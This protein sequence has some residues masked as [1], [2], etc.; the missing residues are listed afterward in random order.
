[1]KIILRP[2]IPKPVAERYGWAIR[3]QAKRGAE[4]TFPVILTPPLEVGISF[5]SKIAQV[6]HDALT[7]RFCRFPIKHGPKHRVGGR[8]GIWTAGFEVGM[9]PHNARLAQA[10]MEKHYG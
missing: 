6:E 7:V 1:M 8:D 3:A 4:P 2:S 5:T 10:F 9:D